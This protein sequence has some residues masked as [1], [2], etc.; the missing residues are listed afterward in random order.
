MRVE[1]VIAQR[2]ESKT[3]EAVDCF[4]FRPSSSPTPEPIT[5]PERILI[6]IHDYFNSSLENGIWLATDPRELC[7]TEKDGTN[8][9]NHLRTLQE[10][11][12]AACTLF[13][14]NKY[15][16]AGHYLST[17]WTRLVRQR[18]ISATTLTYV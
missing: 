17:L 6:S 3:P 13:A 1:D 7:E 15:Q 16:K 8:A 9:S 5:N 4:V 11:S 2:A 10:I 14:K 18:H 12:I